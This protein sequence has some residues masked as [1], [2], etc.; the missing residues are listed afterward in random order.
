MHASSANTFGSTQKQGQLATPRARDC[1][2]IM[3]IKSNLAPGIGNNW[4]CVLPAE[5]MNEIYILTTTRALEKVRVAFVCW[6][7]F[8]RLWLC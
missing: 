4:R 6:L 8:V 3:I 7:A 2:F 5:S 1:E